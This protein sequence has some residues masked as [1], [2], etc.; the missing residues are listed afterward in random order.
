MGCIQFKEIG[1][2]AVPLNPQNLMFSEFIFFYD[3]IQWWLRSDR[4]ENARVPIH[5]VR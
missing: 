1:C 3:S 4:Y 5:G 2:S